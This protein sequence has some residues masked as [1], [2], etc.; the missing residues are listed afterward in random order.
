MM[1]P[2]VFSIIIPIYNVESYL[3][4][5]LLSVINQD[6]DNYEIICVNDGSTDRSSVIINNY[7]KKNN[8]L[9]IIN[10]CNKGLSEARN[11]GI[12]ASIG[13]YLL[14]L[15]GDDFYNNDSVLSALFNKIKIHKYD[16]VC[17]RS[18]LYFEETNESYEDDPDFVDYHS[19]WDYLDKNIF[20]QKNMH[21]VCVPQRCYRKE[22]LSKNKLLFKEDILHEDIPFSVLSFFYANSFAVMPD[23]LYVYRIRSNSIMRVFSLKK[24]FDSIGIANFLIEFID[25]NKE[26]RAVNNLYKY[27][28]GLYINA[29]LQLN[30]S[31]NTKEFKRTNSLVKFPLFWKS[32][33]TIKL[34]F[35]CFLI[36]IN[37]KLFFLAVQI[38]AIRKRYAS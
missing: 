14:F 10:Q 30:N 38:L 15:D 11:S 1:P 9:S 6:F 23:L 18:S 34:K 21:F 26:H 3:D 35:Y 33:V 8:N 19:P 4:R 36:L 37:P 20:V 2:P 12:K 17:F 24:I 22:F 16:L 25:K 27:L 29:Y 7:E 28:A 32:S 13:E 31:G 5:C